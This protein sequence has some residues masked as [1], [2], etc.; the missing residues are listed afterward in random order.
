MEYLICI[1]FRSLALKWIYSLFRIYWQPIKKALLVR[2]RG[3]NWNFHL[4]LTTWWAFLHLQMES[5]GVRHV[6]LTYF[7]GG[8][9]KTNQTLAHK[10]AFCVFCNFDGHC[11]EG[12]DEGCAVGHTLRRCHDTNLCS[13]HFPLF[14]DL[15]D[16]NTTRP[17]NAPHITGYLLGL[18]CQREQR[19]TSWDLS[20]RAADGSKLAWYHKSL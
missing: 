10:R 20:H 11:K 9:E 13:T 12:W 3:R 4:C 2:F 15:K 19:A 14:R 8:S 18:L 17:E 6:A 1:V 5:S 16:V 7:Y